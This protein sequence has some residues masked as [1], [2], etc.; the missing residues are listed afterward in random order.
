MHIFKFDNLD[1]QF[2]KI[3]LF[4]LITAF[5]LISFLSCD[6]QTTTV[7]RKASLPT[8][9]VTVATPVATPTP[10]STEIPI[11]TPT[12]TSTSTPASTATATPIPN[13]APV[14]NAIVPASF[15]ANSSLTITLDY[16]DAELDLASSC[17]ISDL[18]HVTIA[19]LCACNGTGVCT[20]QVTGATDYVGSAGFNYTVTANGMVSN[21]ATA[22][23]TLDNV[24]TFAGWTHV[25]AL[26]TKSA[27]ALTGASEVVASVV[28]N[29]AA[30]SVLSGSIESYNLYRDTNPTLDLTPSSQPYATGISIATLSAT[31]G[32]VVSGTTY[33]YQVA[34]VVSGI[35]VIP[36]LVADR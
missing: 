8:T 22:T 20:V 13:S 28:I 15:D 32:S 34:P 33:Y 5:M 24:A 16:N 4:S 31:D 36:G 3:F 21:S 19:T 1:N 14:A 17:A 26:G 30:M 10:S 7:R 27:I 23:L 25:K 6:G 35:V 2:K 12:P 29:F 9:T 11:A 18:S